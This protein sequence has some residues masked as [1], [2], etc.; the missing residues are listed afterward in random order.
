MVSLADQPFVYCSD[1]LGDYGSSKYAMYPGYEIG[2]YER[3]NRLLC[4][5]SPGMRQ[6]EKGEASHRVAYDFTFGGD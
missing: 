4:Q 1:R 6:L 5:D 2:S 3:F